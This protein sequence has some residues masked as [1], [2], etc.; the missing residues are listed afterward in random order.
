MDASHHHPGYH[1][2]RVDQG[3]LAGVGAGGGD[4][5]SERDYLAE[6]EDYLAE[7]REL[8]T[9]EE[10]QAWLDS[11]PEEEKAWLR[12]WYDDVAKFIVGYWKRLM[13]VMAIRYW[14]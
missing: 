4:T 13:S 12:A 10:K 2:G 14:Y 9:D 6:I 8:K 7:M 1:P 11:L 3:V 5:V